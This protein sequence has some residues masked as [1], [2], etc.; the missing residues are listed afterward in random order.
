MQPIFI[1]GD[2]PL[3]RWHPLTKLTITFFLIS[4]TSLLPWPYIGLFV[5][6][7]VV[8][9]ASIGGVTRRLFRAALIFLLPIAFSLFLIQGI[10]F[11][12]AKV[13]PLVLWPIT[14]WREGLVFAFV[15]CIRILALISSVMLLI[16]TTHPA[17]LAFAFTERGLPNSIGYILLV[18]LQLAPDMSARATAIL[19]TQQSRGL[20]TKGPIRRL[21]ALPSLVGPLVV[22]ALVDVE[23]RAMA[24]ESRAYTASGPK[25]SLRRLTDS[26]AQR[27]ARLVLLLGIVAL[28]VY[29]VA[30]IFM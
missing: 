28:I 18:A 15:T 8:L 16:Q 20:E 21:R 17:D 14:I 4:V 1:A 27:L 30:L 26:N 9:F 12:P 11:P 5:C 6:L 3:H 2:S 25:T 23:E 10:L 29:R 22:G 7:T 24:L 19:E 13:T